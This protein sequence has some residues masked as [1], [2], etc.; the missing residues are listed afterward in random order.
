VR[1]LKA[2]EDI[3]PSFIGS[4]RLAGLSELG[5]Y[6]GENRLYYDSKNQY[7]NWKRSRKTQY[8]WKKK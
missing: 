4:R 6:V 5:Y 7:R 3:M 2:N 8:K 1:V